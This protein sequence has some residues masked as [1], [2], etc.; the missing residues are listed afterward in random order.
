MWVSPAGP[1]KKPYTPPKLT[2]YGELT[3]LTQKKQTGAT[4]NAKKMTRT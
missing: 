4:D 3:Q 2:T 1:S